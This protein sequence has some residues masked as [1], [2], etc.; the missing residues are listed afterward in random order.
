MVQT[1]ACSRY[2]VLQLEHRDSPSQVSVAD[3]RKPALAL[4]MIVHW[5]L[6]ESPCKSTLSSKILRRPNQQVVFFLNISPT[7]TPP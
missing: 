6:L 4:H 5:P 2:L 1:L 3:F 7:C